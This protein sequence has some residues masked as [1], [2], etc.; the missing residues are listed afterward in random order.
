MTRAENPLA[1]LRQQGQAIWLDYI[2]RDLLEGGELERLVR[3]DGVSGVTSN[4]AIFQQAIGETALY[5]ADLRRLL[6]RGRGPDAMALYEELAVDEIRRAAD[7]L[8][9]VYESSGGAD[10][11]VS[12]EVSPHLACETEA[13]VLEAR[14]L[15]RWVDRPNL[16]IKIPAT[17]EGLPAVEAALA[18]GINVNITLMFSLRHYEAVAGAFLRALDRCPTPGRLASVASFFVSR[19]DTAVDRRLD[20]I[21]TPA[22]RALRGRLA[23]AN[24]RLAY[25]RFREI[26]H[27]EAFAGWRRRGVRPQRVLWASTSTKDPAYRDVVYVEEL[28]GPD[29]VNTM[30]PQTLEAFRDH[31]RAGA[32]LLVGLEEAEGPIAELAKLGVDLEEV[33]E[34]LQREGVAKFA[35]P[36][37]RLL[38][39]LE[40]KRAALETPAA[41][42]G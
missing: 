12:F 1:S 7:V 34:E 38:A 27:G 25:R 23:I 33:T 36:F 40:A 6:A 35:E 30:P 17:Q 37:D 15:W 2:R 22:A 18:E 14:R 9:P 32:T 5:D 42:V 13:T 21:G 3:E 16:M 29:T 10:G 26:F 24:S 39:S 19:V 20:E 11:F 31:G 8:A 41:P 28:I 4:P